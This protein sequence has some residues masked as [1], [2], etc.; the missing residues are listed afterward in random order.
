MKGSDESVHQH[1]L[2]GPTKCMRVDD[3]SD[4][5]FWPFTPLS[6]CAFMF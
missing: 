1:S 2:A 3:V 4:K 6:S 5:K